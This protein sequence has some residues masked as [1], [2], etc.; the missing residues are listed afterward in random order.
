MS[1]GTYSITADKTLSRA[2]FVRHNLFTVETSGVVVTLP[3]P[4]RRC[5]RRPTSFANM[6]AGNIVISSSSNFVGGIN[7]IELGPYEVTAI[8]AAKVDSTYYWTAAGHRERSEPVTWTPTL[9]WT[10]A[11]PASVST[12]AKY[13]IQNGICYFYFKTTSADG[14]GATQLTVTLPTI[15]KDLNNFVPVAGYQLVDSTYSNP[16]AYLDTADSTGANRVL[17]FQNFS[18]CTDAKTCTV[19]CAG[20][21]EMEAQDTETYTSTL[22]W[23]TSTPDSVSSVSRVR[24][25]DGVA[26]FF[27]DNR[28]ADAKG[29][30]ASL[31]FTLPT[32][33]P[34]NNNYI[35]VQA[36]SNCVAGDDSVDYDDM[37]MFI[38]GANATAE[39]R[40]ATSHDI[41][42]CA[43]GKA[44]QTYA[45]GIYEHYGWRS[46]T[47]T[48]TWTGTDPTTTVV[49]RY[50]VI[51][52]LCYIL[53][54]VTTSDGNG[55]TALEL[56][57]LPVSAA[58]LGA[59]IPLMSI[60][61][62]DST[63][64]N[65]LAYIKGNEAAGAD[66]NVIAFKGASTCT[67]AKTA[68]FMLAG[69]YPVG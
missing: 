50:K 30:T 38:D 16:Q 65:P 18:T 55:C 21:Y 59:E 44:V 58:Y 47:P 23:G 67:D 24:N 61:L 3:T 62:V 51:D 6:T 20:F 26:H 37:L 56:S 10:T 42:V 8:Q 35:P 28:S 40:V 19:V 49:A 2:R 66:R 63:Y 48:E 41:G 64:S 13:V 34:D 68:S 46:W 39:S 33:V 36:Q 53:V 60:Q 45:A 14:N 27:Q 15:P 12:T 52:K 9:T 54:Y 29:V 25:V 32:F 4:T 5:T 7:A 1:S 57:D 43:N 31:S 17:T 69:H 11:D 22:T